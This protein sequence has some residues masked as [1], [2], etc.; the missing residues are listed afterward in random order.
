MKNNIFNRL[1]LPILVSI[2]IS[3]A[4]V[5]CQKDDFSTLQSPAWSPELAFPLVY[6]DLTIQDLVHAGDSGTVLTTGTDQFATLLY[7]GQT[8]SMDAS[9]LV[10]IP[11]QSYNKAVSLNSSQILALNNLGQ[12]TVSIA[13]IIPIA[14]G[15][16]VNIDSLISKAGDIDIDLDSDFPATV[17]F[18]YTFPGITKNGVPLNSYIE[19]TP[20]APN[21]GPS[22][23]DLTGFTMNLAGQGGNKLQVQFDITISDITGTITPA[24]NA[25]IKFNING[26][27]Y[28]LVYGY[29]GQTSFLNARDTVA[30]RVFD[31]ALNAG[32]FSIANPK[33]NFTVNNSFGIPLHITLP[34]V[35]ALGNTSANPVPITGIPNPI[36]SD[37]PNITELGQ[38]KST[39]FALNNSNSNITNIISQQPRYLF[40]QAR[41]ETNPNGPA[42]NFLTENSK[43]EM[44]LQL[45]MPLYGTAENFRIKDTVPFSYDDLQ[46][47]ETMEL[48]TEVINGFPIEASIQIVFTDENYLPLDSLFIPGEKIVPS[49]TV[50][51]V[52]ER[53]TIPGRNT[54]KNTF[55]SN[56]LRNMLNARHIIVYG[57]A[58]TYNDGNQN[59]KIFT[60][61]SLRIKVGA[62]VKLQVH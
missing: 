59:V 38:T 41:M 43:L 3:F 44:D 22:N 2:V 46:N 31:N 21:S 16:N 50:D 1:P 47:V 40:T 12:L 24:H 58:T 9:A 23:Q 8:M 27:S 37:S 11:D 57:Q 5:S 55:N 18:G 19:S 30:I 52:T 29:F 39:G 6:S 36:P 32:F 56:R 13:E 20:G 51:P 7:D 49:G 33:V 42:Q 54:S 10:N 60:D 28:S 53:V 26:I 62:K 17:R 14:A 34:E 15:Q 35:I 48:R 45:E 4:T 61:Y 25:E